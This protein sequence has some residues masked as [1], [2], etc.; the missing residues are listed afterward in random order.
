MVQPT[1][2]LL[3]LAHKYKVVNDLSLSMTLNNIE[4]LTQILSS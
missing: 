3:T 4:Q 1:A 2:I